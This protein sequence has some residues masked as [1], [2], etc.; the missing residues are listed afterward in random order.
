[1]PRSRSAYTLFELVLTL[2]VI[3]LLSALAYPTLDSLYADFKLASAADQLRARFADARAHATDEG[4]P[5]RFAV[6][7]NKGN[8]RIAPDSPDYWASGDP[9]QPPDPDNPPLV[10]DEALPKGIRFNTPDNSAPTGGDPGGDSS[11]KPGTVSPD[12]WSNPI[13]FLPDGTASDDFKITLEMPG[14]QTLVVQV[15]ALTGAV[16]VK[17]LRSPEDRK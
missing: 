8:F 1:M 6:V 13:S 3:V 10:V 7:P 15:R 14:A 2:A 4:R 11:L 12:Q 9:P 17:P 5:Y 16:T